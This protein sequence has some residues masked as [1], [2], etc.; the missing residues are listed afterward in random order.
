MQH[1]EE[2]CLISFSSYKEGNRYFLEFDKVIRITDKSILNKIRNLGYSRKDMQSL[3]EDKYYSYLTTDSIHFKELTEQSPERELQSFNLVKE[4]AQSMN[5]NIDESYDCVDFSFP[6][7]MYQDNSPI[8]TEEK[9]IPGTLK[10]IMSSFQ[11]AI[12]S[13][14]PSDELSAIIYDPEN[15]TVEYFGKFKD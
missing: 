10:G 12:N 15:D 7:F 6:R 11:K 3:F 13:L 5:F 14:K 1:K 2:H 8:T 9:V 4:I